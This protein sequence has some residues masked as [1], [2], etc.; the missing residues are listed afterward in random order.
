MAF[1]IGLFRECLENKEIR[2]AGFDKVLQY[3]I[4]KRKHRIAFAENAIVYDEKT[5]ASDQLVKQ[6]SRWINT[7]FKYFSNGFKLLLKGLQNFNLQSV[8][9]WIN[10]AKA[11]P[12][13]LPDSFNSMFDSQYLSESELCNSLGHCFCL[14]YNQFRHHTFTKRYR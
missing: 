5:S 1:T 9:V 12:V 7:W 2:G 8:L 13:Y 10:L 6:R 4:V 14:L 3:E 11:T